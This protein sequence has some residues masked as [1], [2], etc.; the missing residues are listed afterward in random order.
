VEW[1]G[2]RTSPQTTVV[3]GIAQGTVSSGLVSV[4]IGGTAVVCRAQRGLTTA[5]GDRVFGVRDMGQIIIIGNLFTTAPDAPD[6]TQTPPPPPE[7]TVRYGTTV[8]AP[9]ETR[10]YRPNWGWRTDNDD[11]YQGEYGNNGNHKGCIFYGKK[12]ASLAGAEILKASFRVKRVQ[13][14]DFANRTSSLRRLAHKTRPG[15]DPTL[16]SGEITGPTLA[17]GEV[18]TFNLPDSWGQ[19]L[20]DRT[21]GCGGFAL[22]DSDGSPYMRLAGRGA[23]SPAF[24]LTLEWK[25]VS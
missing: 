7:S 21:S 6:E 10:S 19:D 9:V 4:K 8:I 17:V 16:I 23:W 11:V 22:F 18:D 3:Q 25:R 24:V 15:G 20:V 1:H 5:A 14:G 12:P 2:L 13:A